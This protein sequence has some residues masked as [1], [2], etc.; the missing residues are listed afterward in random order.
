MCVF[1]YRR[2]ISVSYGYKIF[3]S[4]TISLVINKDTYTG[5]QHHLLLRKKKKKK[6]KL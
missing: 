1:V 4:M 3:T 5:P 2:N 6:I